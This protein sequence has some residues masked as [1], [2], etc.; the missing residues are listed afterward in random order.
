M[1]IAFRY[2]YAFHHDKKYNA[3]E[4]F[5]STYNSLS[6]PTRFALS[7]EFILFFRIARKIGK[8]KFVDFLVDKSQWLKDITS[9]ISEKSMIGYTKEGIQPYNP[10]GLGEDI[11]VGSGKMQTRSF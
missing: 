8:G 3:T 10:L 11:V 6:E 9:K 7:D 5:I 1:D 4:L 2:F